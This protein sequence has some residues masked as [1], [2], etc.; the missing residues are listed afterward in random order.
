MT[1]ETADGGGPDGLHATIEAAPLRRA[2]SAVG[3]LVEECRVR[4]TPAGVAVAA[5]DPATVAMVNLELSADAF[6]RYEANGEVVGVDLERFGDV[7]AVADPGQQVRLDLDADAGL[8]H[9][10]FGDL[11]YALGLV[12]PDAIRSPPDIAELSVGDSAAVGL[13]GSDLG[14]IVD[15]ADMVAGTVELGVDPERPA[16]YAE[17]AGDVDDVSLRRS[18]DELRT[19]AVAPAS[20][21][22]SVDYLQSL[23]REVPGDAALDLRLGE[24]APMRADFGFADGAGS[25]SYAVSPRISRQ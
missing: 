8:L 1:D 21:L 22:F 18:A 11:E 3:A 6:E 2:V 4:F 5:M 17:A 15:A 7:L 13:R 25:V 23:E 9:I 12:D 16:F 19:V 20:S 10:A 14:R 24:E